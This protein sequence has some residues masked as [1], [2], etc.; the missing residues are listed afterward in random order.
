MKRSLSIS[1]VPFFSVRG[2]THLFGPAM[3]MI[4][5]QESAPNQGD[6]TYNQSLS[7]AHRFVTGTEVLLRPLLAVVRSG[8]LP[9]MIDNSSQGVCHGGPCVRFR[10]TITDSAM[11]TPQIRV[12]TDRMTSRLHQDPAQGR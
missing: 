3:P 7:R 2:S 10:G 12:L 6:G 4:F 1:F 11:E 8:F 9:D 5:Y